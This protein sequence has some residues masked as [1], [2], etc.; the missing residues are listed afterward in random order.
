LSQKV[1]CEYLGKNEIKSL[2]SINF[3]AFKRNM[4]TIKI[5]VKVFKWKDQNEILGLGLILNIRILCTA[6]FILF[7]NR[8][9]YD[10]SKI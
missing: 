2:L 4:L 8:N 5:V 1:F 9:E 7:Q 10:F 3:S 6:K